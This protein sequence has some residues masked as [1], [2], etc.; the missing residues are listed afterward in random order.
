MVRRTRRRFGGG[1]EGWHQVCCSRAVD[2]RNVL[3]KDTMARAI[4]LIVKKTDT[5]DAL[6]DDDARGGRGRLP[7]TALRD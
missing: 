2:S 5:A 4:A 3:M 7:Q 6:V 1:G